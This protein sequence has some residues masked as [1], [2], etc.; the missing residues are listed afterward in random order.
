[1]IW[2]VEFTEAY[3]AWYLA[4]DDGAQAAVDAVVQ[5]LEEHGLSLPYP[6]TA[7]AVGSRMRHMAI[8]RIDHK[9]SAYRV[10]YTF[11]PYGRLL[12]L[13]GGE[14]SGHPRWYTAAIA[15]AD[16]IYTGHLASLPI[17]AGAWIVRRAAS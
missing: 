15:A 10:F 1:M 14:R 8:L 17:E 4:L 13:F 11:D 2:K 16:N 5:L 7:A 3:G 12:L 6:C 9:E